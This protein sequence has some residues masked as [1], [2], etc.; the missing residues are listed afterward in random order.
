MFIH[1]V[2]VSMLIASIV[3]FYRKCQYYWRFP[4]TMAVSAQVTLPP[5][6]KLA[7]HLSFELFNLEKNVCWSQ[8][9]SYYIETHGFTDLEL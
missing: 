5:K 2:I 8:F 1:K 7:P 3:D 4:V 9:W 6:A